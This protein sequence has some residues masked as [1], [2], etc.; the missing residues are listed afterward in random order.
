[1]FTPKAVAMKKVKVLAIAF[2][3]FLTGCAGSTRHAKLRLEPDGF[4]DIKWGTEIS[5]LGDMEKV[6]QNKSVN[7]DLAWYVRKG[8][9]LAIGKA[10]LENIFYSFWMGN[11]ESVWIDFK[12][13][14]NFETLK[15]E[16]FER[17]G[18]ARESEGSM[19]KMGKGAR[20]ER[21]PTERARA[22]YAWWGEMTEIFLS[23]SQD[24]HKGTLTMNSRKIREE[25][26]EYEKEKEKENRI[27]ERGF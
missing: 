1:M 6:E 13:D 9:T 22:F 25:R 27:K 10:K 11:F 5:A 7:S 16:L 26:R 8:D 24:R 2:S 17:F 3:I 23:Y 4:R 14:E 12:G 21:L 18:K 15:K 19:E 20:R